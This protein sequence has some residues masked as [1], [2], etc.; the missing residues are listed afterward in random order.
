MK[1]LI[2]WVSFFM[3]F[4]TSL[5]AGAKEPVMFERVIHLP[6]T[7]IRFSMTEDF[8]KDMPAAPFVE[9]VTAHMLN[10]I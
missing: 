7:E 3:T 2:F 9:K 5:M 6:D 10:L 4:L 1:K 8:S